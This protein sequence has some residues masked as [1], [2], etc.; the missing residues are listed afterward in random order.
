[1]T[2]RLFAL[3]V[4][5]GVLIT[6]RAPAQQT[7][8]PLNAAEQF[9][10]G[11]TQGVAVK[12]ADSSAS[13]TL[14]PLT[15]LSAWNSTATPPSLTNG[16]FAHAL[17]SSGN[18]TYTVGG[19]PV[20]MLYL[21][22][23]QRGQIFVPDVLT[24]TVDATGAVSAFTPS[25]NPLPVPRAYH[26]A[27]LYNNAIY[28]V[29]GDV[30]TTGNIADLQ[31]TS[32]VLM[33]VLDANGQPG[34]WAETTAL[35]SEVDT[36]AV[37]AAK[38][39]LYSVGG[40]P[41]DE[42][43]IVGTTHTWAAPI[44]ADGTLGP[45]AVATVDPA[46]FPARYGAGAFAIGDELSVAGGL[47][48]NF[49]ESRPV[50]SSD[51]RRAT[52]G[53]D[54]APGVWNPQGNLPIDLGNI[55]NSTVPAQGRVY[56]LG[57]QNNG[58]PT[59]AVIV[60]T[61]S[62]TGRIITTDWIASEKS[63]PRGL[64]YTASALAGDTLVTAGGADVANVERAEV[65]TNKLTPVSPAAFAAYGTF[66]SA[67]VDLGSVRVIS[68]FNFTVTPAVPADAGTAKVE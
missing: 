4:L 68:S 19:Q 59:S 27:T 20:R 28:V 43:F 10:G 31:V 53:P 54:G 36:P 42:N 41:V 61:V 35:P 62:E 25:A 22:G 23:G 39:T 46:T 11:S 38:G 6:A 52:L 30:S 64:N 24:A 51:V 26:T 1:M 7:P 21:I 63:L 55:N 47:D 48:Y 14:G 40:A 13:F 8:I 65:Y 9:A 34:P 56:I 3:A 2:S 49:L 58:N 16:V 12:G 60:G 45:W 32:S 57:G 29:G 15:E 37:T 18:K 5:A 33:S 44:H 67:V 66:E 50:G 17:V